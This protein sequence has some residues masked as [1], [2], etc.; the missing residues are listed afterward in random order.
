MYQF[1][2]FAANANAAPPKIVPDDQT[3][4]FASQRRKAPRAALPFV[5]RADEQEGVTD[6]IC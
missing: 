4:A 3:T 6:E 1:H 2:C 5:R